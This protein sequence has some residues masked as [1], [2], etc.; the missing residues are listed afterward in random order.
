MAPEFDDSPT[1]ERMKFAGAQSLWDQSED[2]GIGLDVML[3]CVN[4]LFKARADGKIVFAAGV[5]AKMLEIMGALFTGA[6]RVTGEKRED[7]FHHWLR[8]GIYK[9]DD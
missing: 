7:L 1:I 3:S 4:I 9:A 2:L 8:V 5:T 6:S